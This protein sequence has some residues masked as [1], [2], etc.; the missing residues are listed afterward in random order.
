MITVFLRPILTRFF[1]FL[2][3]SFRLVG[4]I[5][6]LWQTTWRTEAW[7]MRAEQSSRTSMRITMECFQRGM[8]RI[9]SALVW[10]TAESARLILFLFVVIPREGGSRGYAAWT[11]NVVSDT[12]LHDF[13]FF[14]FLFF[15]LYIVFC[16]IAGIVYHAFFF[17]FFFTF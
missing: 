6:L 15:W 2:F 17:F 3:P 1:L 13:F 9:W 5:R 10:P 4:G 16:R 7:M 14:V 12:R 11:A 8:H